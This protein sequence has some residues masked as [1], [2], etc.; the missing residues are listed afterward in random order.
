MTLKYLLTKFKTRN[1]NICNIQN[2]AKNKVMYKH[3]NT[4]STRRD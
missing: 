1:I 3:I 4:D 2:K